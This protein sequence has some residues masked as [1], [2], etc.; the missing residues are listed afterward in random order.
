MS[1][2]AAGEIAQI[3]MSE[4]ELTPLLR[5]ALARGD[6]PNAPFVW[7][8][9]DNELAVEVGRLRVA[10]SE[11]LMLVR[12]TG[13]CDQVGGGQGE[14]T[15]S[16]SRSRPGRP[17]SQPDWL[18]PPSSPRA[19]LRNWLRRCGGKRTVAATWLAFLDVCGWSQPPPGTTPTASRT[20]HGR[21]RLP[22]RQQGSPI[23]IAGSR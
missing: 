15:V 14:S 17:L 20:R 2:P 7:R 13:P 16:W 9:L 11:G 22:A 23:T 5:A 12:L 8:D 19:A 10:P 4:D 18:A 21:A 1:G 3:E 6:D